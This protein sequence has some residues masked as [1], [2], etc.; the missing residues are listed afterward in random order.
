M[1]YENMSSS[2]TI[3]DPRA[4]AVFSQSHLRRILLQFALQPRSIAEVASDLQIDIK[5]LHQIVCKFHR[6]G[7]VVVAHERKR[8][9]RAIRLYQATAKSYFIPAAA[10]PGLFSLGL[11]KELREALAF[12]AAKAVKGMLFSLDDDGRVLGQVVENPG[13]AFV[14]LD[15]WRILRLSASRAAQLKQEIFNV[16]D[17]FQSEIDTSGQVFL[18]HAGMARRLEH[19]GATDNR[20]PRANAG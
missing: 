1:K 11:A 10:T 16:L 15:S 19:R 4:A 12:D 13:A 5:Q 18:V 20:K 17:R 14:P 2:I 9:G 8:A 3:Q 6:L 7:L